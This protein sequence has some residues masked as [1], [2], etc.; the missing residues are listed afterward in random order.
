MVFTYYI[1]IKEL[2]EVFHNHASYQT[3]WVCTSTTC[4]SYPHIIH[5]NVFSMHIPT[6]FS[7]KKKKLHVILTKKSTCKVDF[8]FPVFQLIKKTACI[9][10][11]HSHKK[12]NAC[13]SN[14]EINMQTGFFSSFPT[15]KNSMHISIS[16]SQKNFML[17]EPRNQHAN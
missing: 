14:Q 2:H 11:H 4:N 13:Y 1:H 15:H 9:Y 16:F 7:Q 6:S 8:F 5:V 3:S 12:K 10:Q 17:F